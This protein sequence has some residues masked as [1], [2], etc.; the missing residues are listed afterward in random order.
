MPNRHVVRR[1]GKWAVV[2]PNVARAESTHNTQ[3]A[4]EKQAKDVVRQNGGGEVA[5][6][7]MNNLI[8]DK[9]TVAPGHDPRSVKDTK[10]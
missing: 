7:G 1:D 9:D 10:H 2:V 4:A 6:H 3:A 5:I 8:R